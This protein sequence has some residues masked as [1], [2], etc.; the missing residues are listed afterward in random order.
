M[1]GAHD[2]NVV[3]V[4]WLIDLAG[5]PECHRADPFIERGKLKVEPRVDVW[6]FGAISSEA[7]VWL[8]LGPAALKQYRKDRSQEIASNCTTQDG[9]CFHDG[10]RVLEAVNKIHDRLRDKGEIRASDHI[11]KRVLDR[12]IPW[13]LVEEPTARSFS[14][15]LWDQCRK[16]LEEAREKAERAPAVRDAEPLIRR[17]GTSMVDRPQ[18]NSLPPQEISVKHSAAL[19]KYGPPPYD[20][21]YASDS[22]SI[23]RGPSLKARSVK[24]SST[25][26]QGGQDN[27]SSARHGPLSFINTSHQPL[28]RS[29][30]I[31]EESEDGIVPTTPDVDDYPKDTSAM[32]QDN[33]THADKHMG[34][35]TQNQASHPYSGTMDSSHIA[36]RDRPMSSSRGTPPRAGR[37][38]SNGSINDHERPLS[39]DTTVTR[40]PLSQPK[41]VKEWLS[42]EAAKDIRDHRGKLEPKYENLLVHL[43]GRD[44]VSILLTANAFRRLTVV[45]QVF[46]IDDSES[47]K[48]HW[49]SVVD[50][51]RVLAWLVKK[52]D[53]D[54]LDMHFTVSEVKAKNKSFKDTTPAVKILREMREKLISPSNIDL[55]LGTILEDYL[56]EVKEPKSKGSWSRFKPKKVKPLSLYVFTDGEWA[57][58]D[59]VAPL[60]A[61]IERYKNLRTPK[62]TQI[63]IQ[64]IR[65]GNG[66]DGV[67]RLGYLDSGLR[68]KHGKAL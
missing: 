26:P 44:H 53:D 14:L 9:A 46:L 57:G 32:H 37:V 20:P 23:E 56:D 2:V 42:F 54:G 33:F 8:V 17:T 68:R 24:R 34:G 60:E 30:P 22:S 11:T 38:V 18:F 52:Y 3:Y 49:D 39:Q 59:G 63:G 50:L 45:I 16:I 40:R 62:K 13:S 19:G 51:F 29:P 1:V 25:A 31:R 61:M 35:Y 7:A 4:S 55:R 47:M 12:I 66:S 15:G 64:F 6:S 48:E 27:G 28:N 67:S 41:A 5:A 21:Q 58:S 43:K 65:F 36:F 10:E